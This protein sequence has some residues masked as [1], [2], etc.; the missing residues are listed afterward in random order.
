MRFKLVWR[1]TRQRQALWSTYSKE[2]PT[3]ETQSV[4]ESLPNPRVWSLADSVGLVIESAFSRFLGSKART[5][6]RKPLVTGRNRTGLL[7]KRSI[8]KRK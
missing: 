5:W 4:K 3:L 1:S 6:T 7:R 8:S 2:A